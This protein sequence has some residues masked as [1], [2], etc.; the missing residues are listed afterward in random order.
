M[1]RV[2]E[3]SVFKILSYIIIPVL[4]ITIVLS[5]IYSIYISENEEFLEK[6]NY[7]DTE[8]FNI[9]FGN[10]INSIVQNIKHSNIY[11]NYHL[12]ANNIYMD[13]YLYDSID[14]IVVDEMTGKVYTNSY[15]SGIAEQ[16]Y[17]ISEFKKN[18]YKYVFYDSQC[19]FHGVP[20]F[21]H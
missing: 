1:K 20:L 11:Y 3:N 15:P 18:S 14:Y 19:F 2:H 21:C 5:S 16:D 4:L 6:D 7:Y 9:R 10:D 8:I 17:M 13:Y 12:I